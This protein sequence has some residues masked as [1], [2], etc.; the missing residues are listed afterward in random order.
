MVVA[1]STKRCGCYA[2]M[3][4]VEY[5][6]RPKWPIYN[7]HV[8]KNPKGPKHKPRRR[9]VIKFAALR[10]L[11][12]QSISWG[13]NFRI[14]Y[15]IWVL[16]SLLERYTWDLQ[17]FTM[18]KLILWATIWPPELPKNII[19][20]HK[21]APEIWDPKNCRKITMKLPHWTIVLRQWNR[22]VATDLHLDQLIIILLNLTQFQLE[23]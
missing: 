1:I 16:A 10:W 5:K 23:H 20:G 11:V 21:T 12:E 22:W 6:I 4:Q 14:W 9:T 2:H 8:N 18:C 13:H 3:W 15:L 19:Y 7:K 17:I